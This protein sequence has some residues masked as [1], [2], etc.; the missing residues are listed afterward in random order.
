[1]IINSSTMSM[2]ST[3]QYH[4][5][6][7]N[8]SVSIETTKEEAAKLELSGDI[9]E[10]MNALQ[11]YGDKMEAKR[12]E[13]AANHLLTNQSA[14]TKHIDSV[15]IKSSDELKY[16]ILKRILEML[17][18]SKARKLRPID[19]GR[20]M[21][22]SIELPNNGINLSNNQFVGGN[23]GASNTWT[24]TTIQSSFYEEKEV[25]A[26]NSTGVVKTDDG[27]EINFSLS[28][29][30]S[31]SFAEKFD[32]FSQANYVVCDPLV[33]NMNTD[34]A[35]VTDQKFLF[36]L[37]ADGE[38]ESISFVGEG[39]GFLALDKNQD[40]KINDG[41]E[42]FGTK[43]QDGFADLAA[44]DEDLNGWIDEADSVFNDLTVW[45]K[46]EEGNDYLIDLRKAGIGAIYLGSANTQFSLNNAANKT[47]GYLR[48]T[49]VYLKESGEAA[50][51]QHIDLVV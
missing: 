6:E 17:Q 15:S 1:M 30:M 4:K 18:R 46:D 19:I 2:D 37:D 47:N 36:D 13:A 33:I 3:Y 8:K 12:K 9:N 34:S 26:F 44:F 10:Q 29:E 40:G 7:Y 28:F 24:R 20:S 16:E 22:L 35:V 25:S 41:N 5:I 39:S 31:R 43:S 50:T 23:V 48:K 51:I 21:D 42:L 14:S 27:R 32:S 11:E 49:G 45:T 38:E